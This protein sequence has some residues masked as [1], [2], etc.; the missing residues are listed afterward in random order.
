M[1][2]LS[3]VCDNSFL[4]NETEKYLLDGINDEH[5]SASP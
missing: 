2:A 4:Q 5:C 3:A 1:A